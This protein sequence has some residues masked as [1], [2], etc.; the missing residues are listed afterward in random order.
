MRMRMLSAVWASAMVLTVST[1]AAVAQPLEASL[2]FV[3]DPG[4]YIGGGETRSFTLDTA[5]ITAQSGQNGGHFNLTV[6]PFS[7]GFWYVNLSAPAGSQLVPGAY[8]GAVRFNGPG[9]PGL[10]VY[11]DGRGC[12]QVTGR[13]DV[14]E[15]VFGPNGYLERFHAQFEQHC[16]GGEPAL[17]GEVFV[18][19]RPPPPALAIV[20]SVNGSGK[21]ERLTGKA[22]ITGTI[23]CTKDTVVN[24]NGALNQRLARFS[25]ATAYS[26]LPIPCSATPSAWTLVFIPQ[27]TVP[28]GN[29]M[30]QLNATAS[31]YDN[32]FGNQVNVSANTVVKLGPK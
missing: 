30:A 25:L 18:A 31:A 14:L 19:N 3:S 23:R 11:G 22:T 20:L 4:D 32:D 7:G 13:F 6:F 1:G 28:F 8:E 10:D 9:Q 29:G 21:A 15:A 24:L 16:E 17:R 26:W 2:S 27:A 5:A 12:N